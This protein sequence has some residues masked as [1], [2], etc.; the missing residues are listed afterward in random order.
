MKIFVV[1]T[2]NQDRPAEDFAPLMDPEADFALKLYKEGFIREIY[3]RTDG[4][5][6]L[7]VVEADNEEEAVN[8]LSD[9]PLAKAGLLSFDIYGT[10]A[11]RGIIRGIE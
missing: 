1:A 3:S 7:V 2:R 6:A 8:K 11:Y 10:T 5:G 9:L 4:K